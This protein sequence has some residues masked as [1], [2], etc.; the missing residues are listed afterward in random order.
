VGRK[1]ITGP[2]LAEVDFARIKDT[3]IR[4]SLRLQFRAEFFKLVSHPQFGQPNT[5]LFTAA[6]AGACTP[7]G[8]ACYLAN[9]TAGGITT[10]AS[11][12]A[13]RQVQF[14][15]KLLFG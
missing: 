12:T 4:E 2:G 8:E 13:A 11:N 6:A 10:L 14:A 3:R 9:G 5:P 1:T 15:L 7:S